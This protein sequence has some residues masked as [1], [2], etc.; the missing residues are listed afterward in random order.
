MEA[1][2]TPAGT[3]FVRLSCAACQSVTAPC[4]VN[5][6]LDADG[7]LAFDTRQV[8][9]FTQAHYAPRHQFLGHDAP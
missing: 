8:A 2:L 6:V 3:I 7:D 4:R 9:W 1:T 5:A